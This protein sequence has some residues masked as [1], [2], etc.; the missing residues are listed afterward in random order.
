MGLLLTILFDDWGSWNVQGDSTYQLDML[1]HLKRA[2]PELQVVCGNVVTSVQ[3][4]RL[5]GAGADAL[6]VGM[7]SGSI[8]TTQEVAARSPCLVAHEV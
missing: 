4:R 1:A 8:C 5:I 3:A 2:H 6:R 7:G